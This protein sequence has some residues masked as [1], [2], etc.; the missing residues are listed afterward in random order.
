LHHPYN[1]GEIEGFMASLTWLHLSDWHQ[2]G[3]DFDRQVVRDALLDELR[4]REKIDSALRQIDFMVFSGDVAWHAKPEEFQSA[5]ELLF[6]PV[7]NEL[8]L[9]PKNLFIVPGN[10]DLSREHVQEMLPDGLKKPLESDEEVQK[11]LVEEKRRRRAL[12]PFEAYSN[13]FQVQFAF[14]T[15]AE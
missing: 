10:H 13:S 6:E 5:R 9:Q 11:W 15:R 7:L 8:A 4:Q 14:V 3:R 2:K 1:D 12:E